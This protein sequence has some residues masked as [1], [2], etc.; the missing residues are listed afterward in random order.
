MGLLEGMGL[1]DEEEDGIGLLDGEEEGMGLL[2]GGMGEEEGEGGMEEE[3]LELGQLEVLVMVELPSHT[4]VTQPT[5]HVSPMLCHVPLA[6]WHP[7]QAEQQLPAGVTWNSSGHCG[8]P[9][10]TGVLLIVLSAS[11]VRTLHPTCHVSPGWCHVPVSSWHPWH[12]G[13]QVPVAVTWKS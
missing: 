2:E 13:Q 9:H 4:N 5:V 10:D 12:E 6:S 1:F 3:A 11:H 7:S 8:V